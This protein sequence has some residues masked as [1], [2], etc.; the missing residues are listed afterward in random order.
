MKSSYLNAFSVLYCFALR[1]SR[2]LQSFWSK[3]IYKPGGGP[4]SG[5]RLTWPGF[6]AIPLSVLVQN[7]W[8]QRHFRL[9]LKCPD[10]KGT[11][12]WP[13]GICKI[14][15]GPLCM[16]VMCG[17]FVVV[18]VA[19][20]DFLRRTLPA[21]CSTRHHPTT[22]GRLVAHLSRTGGAPPVSYSP[23][24]PPAASNL[25]PS[26]INNCKIPW[27]RGHCPPYR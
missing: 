6:S 17:A 12:S 9:S 19:T 16:R 5:M 21:S 25:R 7:G 18:L 2:V 8:V 26:R 10:W 1:C 15:V 4:G 22:Y 11:C 20:S 27:T 14:G 23:S 24:T 13:V 3:Q